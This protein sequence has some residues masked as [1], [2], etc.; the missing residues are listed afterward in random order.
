MYVASGVPIVCVRLFAILPLPLLS[1]QAPAATVIVLLPYVLW[2]TTNVYLVSLTLVKVPFVPSLT[3]TLLAVNP[4]TALLKVNVY[5]TVLEVLV[6]FDI[7]T[8]GLTVS[9]V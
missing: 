7:V 4:V 8:V 6:F 2:V 3:V 5:V 1:L 9:I